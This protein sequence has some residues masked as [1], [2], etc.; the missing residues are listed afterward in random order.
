MKQYQRIS[1]ATVMRGL[2]DFK[3][4]GRTGY[5]VSIAHNVE[6]SS[7]PYMDSLTNE[8]L[9]ARLDKAAVVMMKLPRRWQYSIAAA[10]SLCSVSAINADGNDF[11]AWLRKNHHAY[12]DKVEFIEWGTRPGGFWS[13]QISTIINDVE[14]RASYTEI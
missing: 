10:S 14:V 12:T 3:R 5:F 11:T 13:H 9:S 1:K 6:V 7:A 2:D 8:E 4:Q